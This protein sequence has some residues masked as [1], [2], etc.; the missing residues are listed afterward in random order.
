MGTFVV[1]LQKDYITTENPD[2]AEIHRFRFVQKE[3]QGHSNREVLEKILA[4]IEEEEKNEHIIVDI[5]NITQ[6]M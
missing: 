6:V 4:W 5:L 3:F 2:W 1:T